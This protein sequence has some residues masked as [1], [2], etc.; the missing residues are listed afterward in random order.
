[1]AV[2]RCGALPHNP[3]TMPSDRIDDLLRRLPVRPLVAMRVLDSAEDPNASLSSI[4]SVVAMDPALSTRVIR[5]ANSASY[6]GRG[7]ITSVERA[8]MLLGATSVRALVA[9]ASFPLFEVDVDLGP[10]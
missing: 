3:A 5:L 10:E 6:S 7:A 4:A 8:V 9:A 1:M 2:V